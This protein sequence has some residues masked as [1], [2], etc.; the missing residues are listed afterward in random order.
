MISKLCHIRYIEDGYQA[1]VCSREQVI[2]QRLSDK[3]LADASRER[4]G[5]PHPSDWIRWHLIALAVF[6]ILICFRLKWT[7]FQNRSVRTGVWKV[8]DYGPNNPKQN[9]I[10][11]AA[12]A[13][14]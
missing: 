11:A 1:T 3:N 5:Q 10:L 2:L 7:V 4:R 14:E 12:S 13:L 9:G 6:E 8:P